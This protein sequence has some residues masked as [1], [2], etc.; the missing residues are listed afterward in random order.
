MQ[1]NFP[2][3]DY[4]VQED[5]PNVV[6]KEAS[7]K[8]GDKLV[9]Y[10]MYKKEF[11]FEIFI[12]EDENEIIKSNIFVYSIKYREE[13][14]GSTIYKVCIGDK[15]IFGD[16]KTKPFEIVSEHNSD[17]FE[18]VNHK[19]RKFI[20]KYFCCE[21]MDDVCEVGTTSEYLI[22]DIQKVLEKEEIGYD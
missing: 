8:L 11:P 5:I 13:D 7:E 20:E 19:L 16:K 6:I 14:N 18:F 12:D 3:F 21:D 22:Y 10:K 2:Y 17:I 4:E 9:K 1:E 15:I